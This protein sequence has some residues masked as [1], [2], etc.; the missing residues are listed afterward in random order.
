MI[1]INTSELQTAI[2]LLTDLQNKYQEV[3]FD[4]FRNVDHTSTFW[5]DTQSVIFNNK[6]AQE[7]IALSKVQTSLKQ[8][9]EIYRLVLNEY[10]RFGTEIQLELNAK[11]AILTN[12]NQCIEQV[13]VVINRFNNLNTNFSFNE[14]SFLMQQGQ[15]INQL[16][17]EWTNYRSAIEKFINQ[18]ESIEAMI[19]IEIGKLEEIIIE[20]F[21][22]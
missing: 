19:R 3:T 15:N 13:N 16:R 2:D 5:Q 18:I 10:S 7:K 4:L 6:I 1:R 11:N 14:K 21:T 20:K 17:I 8:R 9:E 22:F 12:I